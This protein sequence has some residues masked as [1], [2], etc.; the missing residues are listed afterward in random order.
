[1]DFLFETSNLETGSRPSGRLRATV[2]HAPG[3]ERTRM[4][5]WPRAATHPSR[6]LGS[7][8][9][10]LPTLRQPKHDRGRHN[11]GTLVA[12][13]VF[14]RSGVVRARLRA[15]T[16]NEGNRW[17]RAARDFRFIS[18]CD[19]FRAATSS[20]LDAVTKEAT[21][22]A[23]ASVLHVR[24][25]RHL[26]RISMERALRSRRSPPCSGTGWGRLGA[27]V[28]EG[29]G[30]CH[31]PRRA[32]ETPSLLREVSLL[33][34]RFRPCD[35]AQPAHS[36]HDEIEDGAVPIADLLS[37]APANGPESTPHAASAAGA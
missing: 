7:T 32:K 29:T 22:C 11:P 26:L 4:R 35:T 28:S 36:A 25:R 13:W 10:E 21:R 3:P 18:W 5:L 27:T 33:S 34:G 8:G 19:I 1:V 6:A 12:S 14:C 16:P 20:M 31:L 37:A 17:R 23:W 24:G 30:T 9:S 2:A 15:R